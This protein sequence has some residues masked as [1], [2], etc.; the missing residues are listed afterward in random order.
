MHKTNLYENASNC[1][2]VS[3]IYYWLKIP[4]FGLKHYSQQFQLVNMILG[5]WDILV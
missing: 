1:Y 5:N 2:Y 4:A 3:N